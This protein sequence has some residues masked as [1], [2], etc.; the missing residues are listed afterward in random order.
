MTGAA[1][2]AKLVGGMT[3]ADANAYYQLCIDAS[4]QIMDNTSFSLYQPNPATKAEAAKNYQDMFESAS[5]ANPELIYLKPYI[6]GAANSGQGHVTDFWFYPKQ[7][8]L[9][10][11]LYVVEMEYHP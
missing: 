7:L 1:V 3:S 4:K 11:S 6:D 2:D 10:Y 8:L 9:S 5:Y